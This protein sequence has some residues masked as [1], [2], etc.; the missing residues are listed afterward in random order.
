MQSRRAFTLVELLV[1]MALIVFIMAILSEAF[2]RGVASFTTLKAIG[3]LD[4]K[5]RSVTSVMRS[6]L[7]A[8]HFE[9]KKRLSDAN[10]WADGPPREGFFRIWHG[11][12]AFA[13]TKAL[14]PT[15]LTQPL[16][17]YEGAEDGIPSWRSTDHMLHFMVRMR[18]NSRDRFF[19][20]ALPPGSPLSQYPMPTSRFQNGN[21]FN[22][23][24]AE[25]VYFLRPTGRFTASTTRSDAA[26]NPIPVNPIPLYNLY[27]RVIPVVPDNSYINGQVPLN[28]APSYVDYSCH[29]TIQHQP[30]AAQGLYFN[31]ASDLTVPLNR[32]GMTSNPTSFQNVQGVAPPQIP[33]YAYWGDP[34]A[35]ATLPNSAVQ[36]HTYPRIAE[37]VQDPAVWESDLLLTDVL[38]F[39]VRLETPETL[40]RAGTSAFDPFVDL[41]DSQAYLPALLAGGAPSPLAILQSV[42]P[43]FQGANPRVFDSWTNFE[44]NINDLTRI[45]YTRWNSATPV[46]TVPPVVQTMQMWTHVPL[47]LRILALQISIRAWDVKTQQTRQVSFIQDM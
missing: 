43:Q 5:L 35:R 33:V 22:T 6:D 45:D 3:D 1:S 34:T 46:A 11:S 4:E 31:S 8:D 12:P 41:F 28:Q 21:F 18:G 38:S 25:V 17:F 23:P 44:E 42:N 10:L 30:N 29:P 32:F 26:G 47:R 9:G 40:T 37:Q 27:R 15:A 7:A 20:A 36:Y 16:N 2:V 13:G 14:G 39:D 24:I 19:S